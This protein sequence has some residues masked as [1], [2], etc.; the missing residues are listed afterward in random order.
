M[1]P[2]KVG[3]VGC[4]N[5]SGIYFERM[6]SFEILEVAACSDLIT[7]RAREKAEEYRIPKACAPEELLADPE[8]EIVLNLTVPQ[9]HA[10]VSLA[11]LEAGKCVHS[12]KPLALNREDGRRILD[13]AEEK[14]LLV[15][16]A[17]DTFLGGGLQTC[18]KL[19]EDGW[20][21]DPVAASVT[22]M[23]AGPETFHPEP[24]FFYQAGGGPMLDMGP[25]YLTALTEL[26]GP[27]RRVS[28]SARATYPERVILSEPHR[29]EKIEVNVLTHLAGL[30][31]FAKGAIGTIVTS[32]DV[33]MPYDPKTFLYGTRGTLAVPDANT[34]GG[35]ILYRS[36]H[37][38]DWV[39]VPLT[40]GYA[41][42][43]RGVGVADMAYALRTGRPH[44]AS[45]E[46]A[47][48]VLDVMLAFMESA[49][50]GRRVR[51]KSKFKRPGPLPLGLR[52]GVLDA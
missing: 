36:P 7:E 22:M 28:C 46:R 41:A 39:E 4:G 16:C 30:I 20:I 2:V 35:P 40:H 23:Y 9:A 10:T 48:H 21:G 26:I 1:K 37:T 51:I 27:I 18:R 52:E 6:K 8:I 31:D 29:G 17:P 47:F 32:F 45:G 3:V 38:E 13:V 44:R 34:F 43:S 49:S 24:D 50:S 14:G 19:V 5:I 15:G 12:E 33:Q 25:Y 42:N 11:A